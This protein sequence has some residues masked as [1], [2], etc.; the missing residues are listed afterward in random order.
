MLDEAQ[1]QALL[2]MHDNQHQTVV[3]LQ[4]LHRSI[5]FGYTMMGVAGMLLGFALGFATH[6]LMAGVPHG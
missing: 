6:A 5:A 4:K 2:E 1:A 3:L